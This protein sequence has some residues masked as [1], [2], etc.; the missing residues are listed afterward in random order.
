[1]LVDLALTPM[2]FRVLLITSL[3]MGGRGVASEKDLLI[4][5]NCRIE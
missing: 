3:S 2:R 4:P 1:L 5:Y